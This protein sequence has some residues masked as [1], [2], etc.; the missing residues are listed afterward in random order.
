MAGAGLEWG[1]SPVIEQE[2]IDAG[3]LGETFAEA[4]VAV[5]DPELF[6]EPEQEGEFER[7]GGSQTIKVDVRMIA[8]TNR[9]LAEMA[10]DGKFRPDLVY[11]LNVFPIP[12][13][14]LRERAD[15]IP[16]LAHHFV[17]KYAARFGKRIETIPEA[18]LAEL[19]AYAWPGNIRELQHFI[20]RAV[21]LS[22]GNQLAPIEC[23]ARS[24]EAEPG[25]PRTR[26]VTMEQVEREH[27]VRVLDA[28]NW[29]ISGEQGAAVILGMPSTTLR[30]RMER[31][32]IT[33][34]ANH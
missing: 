13:P 23:M 29:R 6:G 14:P 10:R 27:I 2:D 7:V 11:R 17:D 15:D 19:R 21:I 1:E 28:T 30:S 9:D 3:E 5:G 12:L 33:R 4:T 8:A 16:L 26:L 31:L 20:E 32:G 24:V 34:Q 25:N 22:Q 18:T